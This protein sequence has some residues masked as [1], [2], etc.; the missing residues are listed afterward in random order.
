M[1]ALPSVASVPRH[2]ADPTHTLVK[3]ESPD[4][5]AECDMRALP[6]KVSSVCPTSTSTRTR[7]ET[8]DTDFG[9]PGIHAIP[10]CF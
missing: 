1:T 2:A 9:H 8:N 7:A 5:S 10:K 3:G 4:E 6:S